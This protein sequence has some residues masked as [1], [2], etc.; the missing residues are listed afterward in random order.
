MT[1]E[2]EG[3]YRVPPRPHTFWGK[4]VQPLPDLGQLAHTYTVTGVCVSLTTSENCLL[5]SAKAERM[6]IL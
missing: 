4:D 1:S 2:D 5:V 3:I 6:Y